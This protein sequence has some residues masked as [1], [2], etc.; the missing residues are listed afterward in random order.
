[1][2]RATKPPSF[3][4]IDLA[5]LAL[6]LI[7]GA[8]FTII[9]STLSEIPGHAF[10]ALRFA[11]AALLTLTLTWIV[12]RDLRIPR[13]HWPRVALLGLLGTSLYQ[14]LFIYGI[15]RTSASN[16]SLILASSPI[17]VA[18]LGSLTGSEKISSRNWLGVLLSFAGL[19]LLIG[20]S[21]S[22]LAIGSQTL[23]GDLLTLV[24][25][26]TWAIYTIMLKPL[27][28]RSSALRLTAWI[29]VSSIPLLVTVALPDLL[30]LDWQ[31]ISPRSWLALGYSATLAIGIAY[32]IWNTGVQR[33]GSARTSLYS[34]FV[35]LIAVVVAWVFLGESLQP[36]QSLGAVGILLG[37]ALGRY[38]P[39]GSDG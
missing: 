39:V 16:S 2:T 5:L 25:A 7:W 10:N 37:V 22:G 33:I 30:S 21:S 34:Y 35:P 3:G 6:A 29:M 36:L 32:V 1:M 14:I 11:G 38:R 23:T 18:L 12:E 15:A 27:T 20:G 24:A 9:K 31:A 17:F 13:R 4:L 8:N 28:Q 19:S 26:I